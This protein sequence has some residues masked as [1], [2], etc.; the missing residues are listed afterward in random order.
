MKLV[1]AQMKHALFESEKAD[2]ACG[3]RYAKVRRHGA[4]VEGSRNV[5]AFD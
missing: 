4:T 3:H 1:V 2:I 5:A